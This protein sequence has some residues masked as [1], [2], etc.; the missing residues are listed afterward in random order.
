MNGFRHWPG[1]TKPS[2]ITLGG[3]QPWVDARLRALLVDGTHG[4]SRSWVRYWAACRAR[5][6]ELLGRPAVPGVDFAISEVVHCKSKREAENGKAVARMATAACSERYT[7][8]IVAAS[9]ARIVCVMGDVAASEFRS[10]LNLG[11]DDR[12]A[13]PVSVHGLERRFLF[14]DHPAGAG[15]RKKV[16]NA[17][18]KRDAMAVFTAARQGV[19]DMLARYRHERPSTQLA[20]DHL[21]DQD[22]DSRQSCLT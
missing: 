1:L 19:A 10:L 13:G 8:R 7:M 15:H 6:T 5:A 4:G 2:K 9:S 17:L 14:L 22:K 11:S 16:V 21:S 18:G 12:F 3:S 20:V